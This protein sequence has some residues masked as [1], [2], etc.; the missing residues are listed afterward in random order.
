[1][2]METGAWGGEIRE[3]WRR[4]ALGHLLDEHRCPNAC[5]LWRREFVKALLDA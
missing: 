1:M 5:W 2:D 3:G 4:E